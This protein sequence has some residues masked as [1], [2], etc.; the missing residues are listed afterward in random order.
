MIRKKRIGIPHV[1]V[2][3]LTITLA[4]YLFSPIFEKIVF[5]TNKFIDKRVLRKPKEPQFL[6]MSYDDSAIT[7]RLRLYANTNDWYNLYTDLMRK[8][9]PALDEAGIE[10]PYPHRVINSIPIK[11]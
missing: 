6:V 8:L 9:K 3:I 11:K 4:D 10:I 7:V 5:T 2:F 1:V